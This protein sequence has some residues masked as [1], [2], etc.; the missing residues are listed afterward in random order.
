M[1]KELIV[2]MFGKKPVGLSCQLFSASTNCRSLLRAKTVKWQKLAG[3]SSS[4]KSIAMIIIFVEKEKC[5]SGSGMTVVLFMG[6]NCYSR[7]SH[8]I[9]MSV[10]L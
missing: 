3:A 8:V 7:N 9:P 2:G 5:R 6:G 10:Q 4:Y 1:L